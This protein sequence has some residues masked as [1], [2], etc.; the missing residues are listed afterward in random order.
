MR[1]GILNHYS[2]N[3]YTFFKNSAASWELL[4]CIIE[5]NLSKKENSNLA[6]YPA[7]LHGGDTVKVCEKFTHVCGCTGSS[8]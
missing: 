2:I 7:S 6:K 1:L 8:S 5:T 3:I 4:I